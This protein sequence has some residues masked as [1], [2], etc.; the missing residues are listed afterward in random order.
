MTDW[1]DY[2]NTAEEQAALPRHRRV[3]TDDAAILKAADPRINLPTSFLSFSQ[4]NLYNLCGRRYYYK[5]VLGMRQPSS[6]N[7]VHGRMCH[8]VVDK[9]HQYKIH[10]N[11]ETPPKEFYMDTITDELEGLEH[12]IEGFDPKIPDM[13]VFETT[14]RELV[15]LYHE[16]RLPTVMPRVT[17][18]RVVG[19]L[20]DRI[21]FQG[22]I[23]L[24]EQNPMIPTDPRDPAFFHEGSPIHPGDTVIDLKFTGRKYG[25]S[26]VNDS[27]QLTLYAELTNLEHVG[28]DLLV[29]KK[30]SEFVPQR[31]TR[32]TQ[33][34]N[35]VLDIM[36][37]VVKGISLGHFPRTDTE[38]WMCSEKWCP[39]YLSCRGK[40]LT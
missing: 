16:H 15:G 6:S 23:D 31:S 1:I 4:I 7:L 3:S 32:S 2:D 11:F 21:P 27:M 40:T 24:I 34:K 10:H 35:H 20:R 8:E 37:D 36:E 12:D 19:L 33:E 17:E 14:A 38:S 13:N 29:Q 18:Y 28:Y 25:Q 9:M 30:V 26:R 5:Y 22:Y 39:Y